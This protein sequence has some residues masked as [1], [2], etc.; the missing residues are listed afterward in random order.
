MGITNSQSTPN[1][2][3]GNSNTNGGFLS[4]LI[5]ATQQPN[6]GLNLLSSLLGGSK[7]APKQPKPMEVSTVPAAA[8]G[9]DATLSPADKTNLLATMIARSKMAAN[10]QATPASNPFA[11]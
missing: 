11:G 8:S 5:N 7:K 4:G 1:Y 6:A 10:G 9:Y 2:D 3:G